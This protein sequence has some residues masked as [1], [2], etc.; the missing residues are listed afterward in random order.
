MKKFT[1]KSTEISY[2]S[3]SGFCLKTEN[4]TLIIDPFLT[5]NGG[6]KMT[7]NEVKATD[8]LVSHGH[9]D[10]TGDADK[11]AIKNNC[12]IVTTFHTARY[13]EKKGAK[14][15]G[16]PVGGKLIRSWG[17]VHFRTAMHSGFHDDGASF[18]PAASILLMF[19][20]FNMY[21]LGDTALIEDFKLVKEIYQPKLVF[22][23]I[24]GRFTMDIGE[25]IIATKW[26]NPEIVIPMHYNTF[27]VI[28]ADP[29]EFKEKVEKETSAKCIVLEP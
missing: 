23:P 15:V 3:H 5:G 4:D 6:A 28:K 14:A 25:A 26:L 27:D 22:I 7:P 9:S 21:H 24:G 18:G 8:I 16:V 19:K 10:H 20:D 1:Y 29:N 2:L 13:F 12:E 11:I 17:K